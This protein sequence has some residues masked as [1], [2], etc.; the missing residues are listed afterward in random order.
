[1][2]N[3]TVLAG[4]LLAVAFGLG[5]LPGCGGPGMATTVPPNERVGLSV[6][7]SGEAGPLKGP[8]GEN[9]PTGAAFSE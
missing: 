9:M 3:R 4:L 6:P 2:R 5:T 7:G 1:M 8:N